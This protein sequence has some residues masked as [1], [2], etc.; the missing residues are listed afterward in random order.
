MDQNVEQ[1]HAFLPGMESWTQY[2][3]DCMKKEATEKFD[4]V[5][6]TKLIDEFS[7]KLVVYLAEEIQTLLALDKYDIAA[8]KAAWLKFTKHI[9]RIADVVSIDMSFCFEELLTIVGRHLSA[10]N[11]ES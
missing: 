8:V 11:G 4:A 1:H 7:P 10:W 6:F 3:S 2:A 5:H 9:Q